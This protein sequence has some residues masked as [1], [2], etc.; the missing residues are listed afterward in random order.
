MVLP[1]HM[2]CLLTYCL[3]DYL[4]MNKLRFFLF[5]LIAYFQGEIVV[6]QEITQSARYQSC[7]LKTKETPRE[8]FEDAIQWKNE[9]GGEPSV[10]CAAMA[11]MALGLYQ[12]AA[13]RLE[14]I[15]KSINKGPRFKANIL[16]Q[17]GRAWLLAGDAARAEAVATSALQLAPKNP[18]LLI[19]RAQARADLGDY[20]SAKIDLDSAIAVVPGDINALTFRAAAHRYLNNWPLAMADVNAVLMADPNHPEALLERGI[21]RRLNN[22]NAGAR[23]DWLKLL[24]IAP[25]ASAAATARANLEKMDLNIE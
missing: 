14:S 18:E 4:A 24:E 12:A 25:N 20:F 13:H 3:S 1:H 19:N 5:V 7:F 17:A 9:G 10:H 23:T 15:A 6:A 16:K 8:A 2:S 21:L 22:N 11:L